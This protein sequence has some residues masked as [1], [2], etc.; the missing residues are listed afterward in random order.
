MTS[1]F[2]DMLRLSSESYSRAA[3]AI[4]LEE[5]AFK[6]EETG[7]KPHADGRHFKARGYWDL[8]LGTDG[9]E[10]DRRVKS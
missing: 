7:R 3:Y 5:E 4:Q 8:V 2:R 1:T 9:D 10:F 6:L